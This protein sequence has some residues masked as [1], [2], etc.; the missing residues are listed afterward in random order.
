MSSQSTL[1]QASSI[2]HTRKT[3][4]TH[5]RSRKGAEPIVCLTAYT[6]NMA[7]ILDPHVDVLLVGD[8]VGTV[9]HGHDSTIPV[10]LDAMIFHA[11]SVR[12]G[13]RKA[14]MVV[15]LPFGSYEASPQQAYANAARVLKETGADAVK[16]E[17]GATQ[18]ETI[19]FLV[20]RGVPVMGHIGLR[21]QAVR[22]TGGYRIV[23]KTEEECD[24]LRADAD[25]VT[26]AGAFALVLEGVVEPIARELTGRIDIPTIGIGGSPAC[27]G[28]ILVTEDLLGM[29][30]RTPKFVRR[31][32]NLRETIDTA[33]SDYAKAVRGRTF[34]DHD[35]TYGG[36]NGD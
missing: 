26:K 3:T 29:F 6:A 7:E 2:T 17:G 31:F 1:S 19:R 23:G 32:A 8:S 10:T 35:E 25:A 15:D 5:I 36:G 22:E 9:L 34:P 18:R 28:Q 12:R 16:L 27:D 33:I 14:L 20:E 11:Q 30:E 24:A 13:V 4:T 21:P